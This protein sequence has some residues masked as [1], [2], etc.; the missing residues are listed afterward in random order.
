MRNPRSH[1]LWQQDR[2]Q[3]QKICTASLLLITVHNKLMI[4]NAL[5]IRTSF[6]TECQRHFW[7]KL[8][9]LQTFPRSKYHENMI[10]AIFKWS[11]LFWHCNTESVWRVAVDWSLPQSAVVSTLWHVTMHTPYLILFKQTSIDALTSYTC[12]IESHIIHW[13]NWTE[14]R[15]YLVSN[16][17]PHT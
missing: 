15:E 10:I 7:L 17:W 4:N 11:S 16:N 9:F 6:E 8:K 2:V 1:E 13:F 12:Y 14:Y 3:V 5:G